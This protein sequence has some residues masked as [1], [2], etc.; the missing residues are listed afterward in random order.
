MSRPRCTRELL[1]DTTPQATGLVDLMRRL[2][3]PMDSGTRGY[4]RK[5]LA[6]Y[7]ID[8]SHFVDEPLP[9]RTPQ[10]Y[11]RDRLAE[12][13][14]RSHSLADM[15]ADMGVVPYAGAF[16]YLRTK[17]DQ[18]GIDTSHFT[19]RPSG[20]E[21][22]FPR[23]QITR[24]VTESL[25]MAGVMRAARAPRVERSGPYEGETQHRGIRDIDRPFH[26]AGSHGRKVVADPQTGRGHPQAT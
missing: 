12:A 22:L 25:S 9:E 13:A 26:R 11:T 8:V 5:R 19:E 4:L 2:D 10:S 21:R 15:L 14:G 20:R 7:G 24:A 6:H 17:L 16:G 3:M 18:Y 23:E 1:T